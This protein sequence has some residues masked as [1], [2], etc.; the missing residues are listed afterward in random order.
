MNAHN[1]KPITALS[2]C[3]RC[4]KRRTAAEEEADGHGGKSS[5][6]VHMDA[7]AHAAGHHGTRDKEEL[8]WRNI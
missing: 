1:R 3:P 4:E 2:P 8:R 5:M 7:R 6:G